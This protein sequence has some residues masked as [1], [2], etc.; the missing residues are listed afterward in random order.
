MDGGSTTITDMDEQ[1]RNPDEPGD[2]TMEDGTDSTGAQPGEAVQ[3]EPHRVVEAILFA[4]DSPIPAAKVASILG[5]GTPATCAT[6]LFR[7]TMSTPIA[8]CR[9]AFPKSPVGFRCSLC[10]PTTHG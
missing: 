7:L 3:I 10:P 5:V 2:P 1:T 8:G 4:S 9:F 6:T